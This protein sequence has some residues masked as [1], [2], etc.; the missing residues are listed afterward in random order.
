MLI[1]GRIYQ[2]IKRNVLRETMSEDL[3]WALCIKNDNEDFFD[4]I[5]QYNAQNFNQYETK[6]L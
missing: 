5:R 3:E 4:K 2:S 6:S 1:E